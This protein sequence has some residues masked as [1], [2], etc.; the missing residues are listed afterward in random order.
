MR[1]RMGIEVATANHLRA[2]TYIPVPGVF[3][4]DSDPCNDID[5]PYI[6]LSY[7]HGNVAS[8][9]SSMRKCEFGVF[10]TPDQNQ[11]FWRQMAEIKRPLC[12][13]GV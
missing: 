10:G 3:G 4:H 12:L 11:G 5:A 13:L 9:L 2:R 1:R 6:L 8:D 7:I